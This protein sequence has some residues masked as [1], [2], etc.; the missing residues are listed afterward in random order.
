MKKVFV[1]GSIN[2]DLVMETDRMPLLGESVIGSGFLANQGGKGA[3][4]A[5]ACAKL[6]CD[7]TFL[8]AVG[9]DSNGV[10]LLESLRGFD[11]KTDGVQESDCYSGTCIILF[12]RSQRDNLLVVDPGANMH[13]DPAQ[14]SAYLR[15]HAKAGD[16][17]I[18]Q[19]ETNLDAVE[20]GL[21]VSKELGLFTVLNPAPARTVGNEILQHVDLI[22]PNETETLAL[23]GITPDT[24]E[25]VWQVYR[26]F[27]QLGVAQMIITLGKRGSVHVWGDHLAWHGAKTVEAVDTTS[28]GDTFIGAVC[29][30]LSAGVTIEEAIDYAAV[31]S[32]IT[33]SRRG[34]AISIPTVAEVEQ[35]LRNAEKGV[36]YV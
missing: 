9:R 36:N 32:A 35:Y 33:V 27:A 16:I 14:V 2:M 29:A 24:E 25:A 22:V 18:T 1:L 6:G 17:F 4:Q 13:I 12:D 20:T 34:A 3:N 8:G 31:C 23:T 7:C 30:Q 11:V 15:Q 19:L 10:Q 5:V 21:A 28:A 26:H